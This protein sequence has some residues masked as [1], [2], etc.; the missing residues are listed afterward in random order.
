MSNKLTKLLDFS[1]SKII[2]YNGILLN[3][4]ISSTITTLH[5]LGKKGNIIAQEKEMVNKVKF[6]FSGWR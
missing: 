3:G 1:K 6:G 2:I 4:M 5:A